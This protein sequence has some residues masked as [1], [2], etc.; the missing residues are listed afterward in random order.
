MIEF[1]G[2]L[3][4]IQVNNLIII[5]TYLCGEIPTNYNSNNYLLLIIFDLKFL[6]LKDEKKNLFLFIHE[7][8]IFLRDVFEEF[9]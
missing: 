9:L 4:I 3:I 1:N 7:F 8:I 5:L 2:V 6:I